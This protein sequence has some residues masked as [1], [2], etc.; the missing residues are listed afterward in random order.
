MIFRN[1]TAEEVS[2]FRAYMRAN[3]VPGSEI[4]QLWHP[5]C[6]DEAAK[7]NQEAAQQAADDCSANVFTRRS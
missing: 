1:L 4:D 5:V 2:Q 3:Y 7:M 6:R